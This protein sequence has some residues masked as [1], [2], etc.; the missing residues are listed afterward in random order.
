MQFVILKAKKSL[1]YTFDDFYSLK[2]AGEFFIQ[3]DTVSENVINC[4]LLINQK[5]IEYGFQQDPVTRALT[6]TRLD[7]HKGSE[8]QY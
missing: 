7:D 2:C 5:S 6:A 1:K 3:N 4:A 8:A